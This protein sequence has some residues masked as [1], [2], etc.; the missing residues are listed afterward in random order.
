MK[1]LALAV[2][3]GCS[4]SAAGTLDITLATAPGSHVMDAVQTLRLVVTN[5]HQVQMATRDSNGFTIGIDLDATT[6]QSGSLIVDGLDAAGT[7]VATGA[8]PT[9]PIGTLTAKIVIYMAAP[10]TVAAAPLELPMARDRVGVAP[11]S[12]GA[13]LAG[14]LDGAGAPSNAIAIYNAYDHT[15]TSGV[16]LPGPR[17]G[18]A[19]ATGTSHYVYLF[20][21]SDPTGV[22]A[23]NLWRFDTAVA[24]AG[25]VLDLGDKPGFER[26]DQTALSIGNEQFLVTG[27]PAV[28]V[29]GTDGSLVVRSEIATLPTSA[30]AVTGTDG[31]AA[32]IFAGAD[33]VTRFR[34]N[35]FD[36]L[37][38]SARADARVVMLPGGKVG[39]VCGAGDGL[40]IDA[41]TGTTDAFPTIPS[42]PRTGCAVAATTRHLVI[43]GGTV[44]ATGAVA[45]TAEIY[46]A[47]TLALIATVP[48][49]VPRTGGTAV[50]L[51][52]DQI[53][54]LSG[55]DAAGA[56]S[57]TLELF[58]PESLE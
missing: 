38:I 3:A 51:P 54:I 55:H 35:T 40:R 9:F 56:P 28:Q 46:D 44:T 5:P 19:I 27:T 8:S 58:T 49:V 23:A 48:L 37:P 36:M 25:A 24:P 52:N 4:G 47:A 22:P 34:N 42:E 29:A 10:N 16:A 33:G 11:L 15:L 2:L 41:A 53:L 1:R 50:A 45:T 12:Y 6:G 7:I 20:G 26:A 13:V 43:A 14:G 17:A 39:V 57:G 18:L 32:A 31:V 30:A 21:G